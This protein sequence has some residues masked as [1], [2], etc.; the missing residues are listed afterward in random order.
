MLMLCNI[1]YAA[2]QF[3]MQI[4]LLVLRGK[5]IHILQV[6]PK[7]KVSI[8]YKIQP[9][10]VGFKFVFRLLAFQSDS[11]QRENTKCF[12]STNA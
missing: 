11:E 10:S 1:A 5:S 4:N 12:L 7:V 8:L 6:L 3:N 9:N 2:Q